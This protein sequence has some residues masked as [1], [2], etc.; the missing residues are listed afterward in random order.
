MTSFAFFNVIDV[1]SKN[2]RQDFKKFIVKRSAVW[3]AQTL[4]TDSYDEFFSISKIIK[5]FGGDR[6]AKLS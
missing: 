3:L 1:L 6:L 4:H 5:Q 2:R